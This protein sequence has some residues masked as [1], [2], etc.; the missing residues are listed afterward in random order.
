MDAVE[1]A[2]GDRAAAVRILDLFM[3]EDSHGRRYIAVADER[4]GF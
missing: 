2:D 4:V 1:I 3:P